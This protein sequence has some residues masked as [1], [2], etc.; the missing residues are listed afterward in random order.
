MPTELLVKGIS[1]ARDVLGKSDSGIHWTSDTV[2]YPADL[3]VL[4]E[5][6]Y[7]RHCSLNVSRE[8]RS[9]QKE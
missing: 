6:V 4:P 5:D 8:R 9:T 2:T 3:Q 1:I 7:N